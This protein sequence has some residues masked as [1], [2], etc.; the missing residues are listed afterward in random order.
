MQLPQTTE[1]AEF[2][3][4][5]PNC[6]GNHGACHRV[7]FPANPR[8]VHGHAQR[9]ATLREC[10][11]GQR[12]WRRSA[13]G[14][15]LRLQ[16][17][18]WFYDHGPIGL[19]LYVTRPFIPKDTTR[20]ITASCSRTKLARGRPSAHQTLRARRRAEHSGAGMP[21]RTRRS[22][23]PWWERAEGG[24]V[25]RTRRHSKGWEHLAV[26]HRRRPVQQLLQRPGDLAQSAPPSAI[27]HTMHG[28]PQLRRFAWPGWCVEECRSC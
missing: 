23:L 10:P 3:A 17:L 12:W 13:A 20:W 2:P 26:Q 14:A 8:R 4:R 24:S 21:A 1:P 22:T 28:A 6:V 18:T 11:H 25:R 16:T 9:R 5:S 27:A 15:C 19:I 7:R